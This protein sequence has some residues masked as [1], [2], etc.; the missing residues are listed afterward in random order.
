MY[1]SCPVNTKFSPLLDTSMDRILDKVKE[2]EK[3]S[4]FAHVLSFWWA[5]AGLDYYFGYA[6]KV[7]QVGASDIEKFVATYIKGKPF[8]FGALVSPGMKQAGLTKKALEISLPRFLRQL[9]R[10]L[11]RWARGGE[12][13]ER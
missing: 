7:K 1:P 5:S 13:D 10:D 11:E 4:S 2:R 8:V 3:P 6:D 12:G 9:E